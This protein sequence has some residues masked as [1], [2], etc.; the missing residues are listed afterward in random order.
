MLGWRRP[1]AG[2]LEGLSCRF[3]PKNPLSLAGFTVVPA[4][5][6]II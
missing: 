3:R 2:F 5:R 6:N 1:D 4:Q